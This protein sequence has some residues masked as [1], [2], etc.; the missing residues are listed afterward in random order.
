MTVLAQLIAV[1]DT[2]KVVR[3]NNAKLR[4][5]KKLAEERKTAA[6]VFNDL[7]TYRFHYLPNQPTLP[8]TAM[9]GLNP[10]GGNALMCPDCNRIHLA[11]ACSVFSGL[12]FPAC[13]STAA[14]HRL[15]HQIKLPDRK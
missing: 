10:R 1:R 2:F 14:G 4:A 9:F 5:A 6:M 3:E 12:Q 11:A 7:Y 13:C 8:G 15:S